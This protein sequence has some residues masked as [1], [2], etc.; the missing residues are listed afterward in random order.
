MFKVLCEI[1]DFWRG[2][3]EAFALLVCYGNNLEESRALE[4]WSQAIEVK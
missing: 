1:S 4:G 2:V 3:D